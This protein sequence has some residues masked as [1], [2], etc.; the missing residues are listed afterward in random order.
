MRWFVSSSWGRLEHLLPSLLAVNMSHDPPKYAMPIF[1]FDP[2][3]YYAD[4]QTGVGHKAVLS[5]ELV[6]IRPF[7]QTVLLVARC[8][9]RGLQ[10]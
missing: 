4:L 2:Q 9:I 6:Q 1:S 8:K 10:I 5:A 3:P 7:S